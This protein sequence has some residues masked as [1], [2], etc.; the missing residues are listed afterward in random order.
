MNTTV[1][2]LGGGGFLGRNLVDYFNSNGFVATSID[3]SN[4][5]SL[6]GT[7]FDIFINANGNSRRFWAN[8]HPEED[9]IASVI[10]VENSIKHFGFKKY[11]FISSSDTYPDHHDP[12]KT[13][14]STEVDEN[15]L[16]PYG[17]HKREAEAI[18]KKL[19]NHLILRCSAMIGPGLKKGIV[20][21][22]IEGAPLFVTA[23][24]YLQFITTG[25][26]SKVIHTLLDQSVKNEIFNCG[27]RGS[28]KVS[29]ILKIFDK[30]VES[31]DGAQK[32]AYEMGVEKLNR[33]FP[34]KTSNA[35]LKEFY[36][37]QG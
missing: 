37:K 26:I 18:V 15:R 2:I 25:E 1:G 31:R 13:H 5:Q 6:Q 19:P 32:Q 33:I 10:S 28:V 23:D 11:I 36:E 12:A 4:Y 20:K 7:E 22:V 3:R 30:T 29:E 35:Y 17:L 34:L 21:D 27:G 14:E 16:E 9:R 24:S 8:Q